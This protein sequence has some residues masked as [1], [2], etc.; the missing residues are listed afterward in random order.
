[1]FSLK[2]RVLRPEINFR[3]PVKMRD[4]VILLEKHF[5]AHLQWSNHNGSDMA[6]NFP[7]ETLDYQSFTGDENLYQ[8][9]PDLARWWTWMNYYAVD[10]EPCRY[11]WSDNSAVDYEVRMFSI[12]LYHIMTVSGP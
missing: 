12:P 3:I 2:T 9:Q 5:R 11:A 1:M 8:W 10:L 7:N 4:V 6:R